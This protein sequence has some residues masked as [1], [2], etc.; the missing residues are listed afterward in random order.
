LLTAFSAFLVTPPAAPADAKKK[1]RSPVGTAA[2]ISAAL[3]A[4]S[5]DK[6]SQYLQDS[7]PSPVEHSAALVPVFEQIYRMSSAQTRMPV[8]IIHFGDSHTAADE[9]TGGLRNHF[10]ERF[11]DGGSGFSLAGHPF[12]GYRR[13]DARGGGTIGWQSVGGRAAMGDGLFGLGGFGIVTWRPG[14]S[15]FLN[16]ECDSVE[17]HYLQQPGGGRLTL[18]DYGQRLDDFST[19]GDPGP[20]F[21]RYDTGPGTHRFLLKTLDARPVRLFG[22]VADREAGVTY[23]ALGLNGAEASVILKW[24]QTMLATYLQRR[25][26]G[27]IV[28]AYGTNEATDPYWT[29]EDYQAMFSSLLR[30]LRQDAPA[31]SILVLGP[32]DRWQRYQGKWRRV[33]GI[34]RI[35]AAEQN[36]C[37]E[38][39]C[40]FWDTRG[41]MGGVGA[42][43]DWVYAGLAQ[44]DHVHFTDAGYRRLADVLFADLMQQYDAYKKTRSETVGT[45]LRVVQD[46]GRQELR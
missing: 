24:D 43:K 36:A 5:L 16:A 6:V 3:R 34:D 15:V 42:M 41:R 27:M 35:V 14:Q 17:I 12:L 1:K 18:Y 37:R 23:E 33:T 4:A 11:G 40:A 30:R 8:H 19:D 9:W 28:L 7:A 10:R 39:G 26:P 13:F 31:A 22:W 32:A 25:N 21:F 38:N 20:G 29:H 45:R 44:G 2:K 46:S